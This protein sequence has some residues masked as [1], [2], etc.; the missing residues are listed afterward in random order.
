[1]ANMSCRASATAAS[2]YRMMKPEWSRLFLAMIRV[3]W[4]L[5]PIGTA[6]MTP[7]HAS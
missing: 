7:H 5:V 1:M 6:Q 4:K 2:L 3:A